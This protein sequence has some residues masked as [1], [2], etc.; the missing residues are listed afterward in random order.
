MINDRSACSD[1][2]LQARS[3]KST[4][5][6]DSLL[7]FIDFT[8]KGIWASLHRRLLLL[9][10]LTALGSCKSDRVVSPINPPPPGGPIPGMDIAYDISSDGKWVIY[11]HR[12]SVEGVQGVYTL[13]L[14]DSAHPNLLLPDSVSYLATDCRI[15]PDGQKIVY[16]RGFSDLY[17]LD[18][19]TQ[20][21]TQITFTS[22]NAS[23]PDWDPSGRF[24]AYERPL[25]PP[26]SPDSSSGLRILDTQTFKDYSLRHGGEPTFGSHPRWSPD[27]SRIAF[28]QVVPWDGVPGSSSRYHVLSVSLADGTQRDLTLNDKRNDE[29]PTWL[30]DSRLLFESYSN[31]VFNEHGTY[32]VNSSGSVRGAWP[33]DMRPYVAFMAAAPTAGLFIY[34]GPDSSR[35]YGVLLLRGIY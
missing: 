30:N 23:S 24:I 12:A 11:R 13:D 7:Y 25:I 33:V 27:G 19:S 29:Y 20:E 17:V 5:S 10:L 3:V 31:E 18:L 9:L 6:G 2:L 16:L 4:R 21:H 14:S 32:T 26:G 35:T 34:T 15:S 22:G 28:E 1:A 8:R